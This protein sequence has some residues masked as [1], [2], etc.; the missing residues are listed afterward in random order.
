MQEKK[1]AD[2]KSEYTPGLFQN[3]PD[4]SPVY[5]WRNDSDSVVIQIENSKVQKAFWKKNNVL[6]T[7]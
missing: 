4:C 6:I 7:V 5:G 2:F 3:R 1:P